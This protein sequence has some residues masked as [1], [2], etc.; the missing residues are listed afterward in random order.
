MPTPIDF[1]LLSQ[2]KSNKAGLITSN[3]A[4]V[5]PGTNGSINV[6][7]TDATNVV[8]DINGYYTTAPTG[9]A[10]PDQRLRPDYDFELGCSL[11]GLRNQRKGEHKRSN[12][13]YCD[14]SA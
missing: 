7:V 11:R 10:H 1:A 9:H 2:P 12:W 4:V 14:L 5:P 13:A 3:S 8:I 6:F